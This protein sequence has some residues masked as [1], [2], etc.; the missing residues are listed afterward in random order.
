MHPVVST[1]FNLETKKQID[2][3]KAKTGNSFGNILRGAL[4]VQA[5]STGKVLELG[6]VEKKRNL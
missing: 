4:K 3:I 5:E 2:G 1:R 6:L